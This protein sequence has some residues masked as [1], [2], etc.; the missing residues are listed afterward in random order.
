MNFVCKVQI[1]RTRAGALQHFKGH[2]AIK[3]NDYLKKKRAQN[4]E[5]GICGRP[6]NKISQDKNEWQAI[7]NDADVM[8][9]KEINNW[10]SGIDN[11]KIIG[12]LDTSCFRE[13]WRRKACLG[14]AQERIRLQE[15]REKN[16]NSYWYIP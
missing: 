2:V 14:W 5:I 3:R 16:V 7:S 1:Q 10:P 9:E 11:V 6:E 8:N 15:G 12:D 13:I 4:Q